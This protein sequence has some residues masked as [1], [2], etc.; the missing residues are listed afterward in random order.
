MKQTLLLLI[1]VF[2]STSACT[3]NNTP[4]AFLSKAKNTLEN[5]EA[6]EY[7]ALA[8]YPDPTGKYDTSYV[9][10]SFEKSDSSLIGYD[11]VV[12]NR[13]KYWNTDILY[14]EGNYRYVDHS[15]K[16]VQLFAK[17]DKVKEEN[18][19]KSDNHYKYSPMQYYNRDDWVFISD[20]LI[21]DQAFKNFMRIETDR[22]NDD[23]NKILT[24][25]HIFINTDS[26][27]IER[28]ERRNHFNGKLSQVV[29]YDYLDYKDVQNSEKLTYEYPEGYNTSLLGADPYS[30]NLKVG[31]KAPDF[32]ASDAQNN[33]FKLA[34]YKGKKVLLDF[35]IINCGYC[36]Q[37]LKHF[38]S[39]GYELSDDV[40]AV[41]INPIDSESDM[42]RFKE[43]FN[44][45]F[46]LIQDGADEIAKDY[47][48]ITY[49]LFYLINEEGVIEK[50]I[51]GFD[52]EFQESLR[53]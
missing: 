27:L 6:F 20:T 17:D 22:V 49:P 13:G 10:T 51:N 52:K 24:E 39:E 41:Y 32:S 44:I 12:K 15:D 2:I 37:S 30:N 26:K 47:G 16:L 3:D 31:D 9:Y 42:D 33:V 29:I 7:T 28:F 48:V 25:Q 35:S 36:L 1:A 46:P 14:L 4:E 5:Y 34:D 18:S 38:N 8:Q 40:V 19:I 23:G 21:N 11:Y 45:P 50:V 53:S 43:Q